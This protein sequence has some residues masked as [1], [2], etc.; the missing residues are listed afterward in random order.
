M[1]HTTHVINVKVHEM[2]HSSVR[3]IIGRI[4]GAR[5]RISEL[6]NEQEVCN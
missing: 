4:N 2:L 3:L 5:R 1:L 6:H